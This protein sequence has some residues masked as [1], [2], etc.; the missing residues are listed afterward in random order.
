MESYAIIDIEGISLGKDRDYPPAGKYNKIHVCR[1]KVAVELW[2]GRSLVLESVPCVPYTGLTTKERS[3]FSWCR[4]NIHE[5]TYQP[6]MSR[7]KCMDV[8]D[9]IREFFIVNGVHH[10]YYKGGNIERDI[11]YEIGI[12][13]FNLEDIGVPKAPT[14][15]RHNPRAD[16][17]FYHRE[18]KRILNL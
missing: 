9:R 12:N 6:F 10:A 16:V 8:A 17:A 18:M 5:L 15:L 3:S 1:R 7:L 4:K 13:A 14:E 11:C 2:D